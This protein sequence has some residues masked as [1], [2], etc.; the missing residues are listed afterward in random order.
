[1]VTVASDVVSFGGVC[2]HLFVVRGVLNHS[3]CWQHDLINATIHFAVITT[4]CNDRRDSTETESDA[5]AR[6]VFEMK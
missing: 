3:D 5:P 1:M 6:Y 4:D 2:A